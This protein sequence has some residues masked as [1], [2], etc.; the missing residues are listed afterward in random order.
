MVV[1]KLS[2]KVEGLI[3]NVDNPLCGVLYKE[4]HA[5]L[6]PWSG[7][8]PDAKINCFTWSKEDNYWILPNDH[9]NEEFKKW[10]GP[11]HN[12]QFLS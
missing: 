4:L 6:V 2:D 8:D 12:G 5:S 9:Y 10:Q 7:T 3:D 1:V 11:I